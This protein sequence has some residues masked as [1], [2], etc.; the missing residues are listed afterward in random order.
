MF[1]EAIFKP[2]AEMNYNSEAKKLAGKKIVV[3]QGWIVED[4]PFKGQECFYISKSTVGWI[5][6]CD[7]KELKPIS[8]TR[9][10]EIHKTLN[11]Q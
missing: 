1:Y 7:L 5:P 4:G 11:L 9:W 3:Q 6:K 8:F 10:K 2:S